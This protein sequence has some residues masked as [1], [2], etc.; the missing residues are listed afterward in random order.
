MDIFAVPGGGGEREP[1]AAELAAIEVEWPV[2]EAELALLD[3]EIAEITA[4]PEAAGL[5][6]R[7]Y[8]R[9][10]RQV[11]AGSRRAGHGRNTVAVYGR[12]FIPRGRGVAA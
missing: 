5:A 7:R 8:R 9:L 1:S 3:A 12:R 6:W 11:L 2:I 10:A 4:G